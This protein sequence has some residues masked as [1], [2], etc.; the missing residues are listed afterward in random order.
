MIGWPYRKGFLG[1]NE[2]VDVPPEH[3]ERL[4]LMKRIAEDWTEPFRDC[5]MDIPDG[6][7]VQVISLEDFMPRPG[8]WDNKHGRVTMIGEAAHA[9]TMCMFLLL[10]VSP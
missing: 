6:T 1:G 9:M 5:V 2:P 10:T 4:A 8:M 3:S 7:N